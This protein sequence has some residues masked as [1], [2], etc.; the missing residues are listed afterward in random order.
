MIR[1]P[2]RSTL[3][4][5]TTLFR[6]NVDSLV[7]SAPIKNFDDLLT[8]RV[9]GVDVRQASGFTGQATNIR[10]RGIN[11]LTV[12]SEPIVIADGVR[13]DNQPGDNAL[14]VDGSHTPGFNA[15]FYQYGQF[16]G[17]LTNLTPDEIESVEVV[18][19]ASA[20]TLYGTDAA[21][22]VIVVTTKHGR[23]GK[24]T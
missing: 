5:Y 22:G 2:P 7:Q 21:N 14:N 4:P 19:G 11:S 13:V 10:I 23:G 3:F 20:A 24:P 17:A 1:R 12:R 16:S 8:A 18:K 9:P 15:I 6:S